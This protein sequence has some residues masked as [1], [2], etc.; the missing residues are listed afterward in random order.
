MPKSAVKPIQML[1]IEDEKADLEMIRYFLKEQRVFAFELDTALT[2]EQALSVL[3][4]RKV[5]ICLLDLSLPDAAG[6]DSLSRLTSAYAQ[7]PIIVT[8]GLNDIETAK[9]A[10]HL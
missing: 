3:A 7:I 8:T 4:E 6:L 9:E 10:I 2:L 1:I 5:D